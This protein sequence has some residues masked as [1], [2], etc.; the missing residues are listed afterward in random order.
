MGYH[1]TLWLRQ[2]SWCHL[3]LK[4]HLQRLRQ[5]QQLPLLHEKQQRLRTARR[6]CGGR[7]T[8][9]Q[10]TPNS[11]IPHVRFPHVLNVSQE[12]FPLLWE[13]AN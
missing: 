5:L 6:Q 3:L 10:S 9:N 2:V 1:W 7:N 4:L 13:Q 12:Y 11:K 8:V